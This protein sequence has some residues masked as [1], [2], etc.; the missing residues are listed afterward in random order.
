MMAQVLKQFYLKLR[1]QHQSVDST[2]ITTRQ[3]ESMIRLAQVALDSRYM[4]F[5]CFGTF[6]CSRS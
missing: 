5:E 6:M 2:P 3:L 4:L 1:K